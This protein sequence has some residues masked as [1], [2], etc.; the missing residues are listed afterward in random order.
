MGVCVF[1]IIMIIAGVPQA[2]LWKK[3]SVYYPTSSKPESC[4]GGGVVAPSALSSLKNQR[5]NRL[6][7]VFGSNF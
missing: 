1:L 6:N 4:W 3:V 2:A 7:I 5:Q